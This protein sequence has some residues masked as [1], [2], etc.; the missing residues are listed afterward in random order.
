MDR[1]ELLRATAVA[2]GV[3]EQMNCFGLGKI[4]VKGRLGFDSRSSHT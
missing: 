3:S 1:F 4:I 2:G